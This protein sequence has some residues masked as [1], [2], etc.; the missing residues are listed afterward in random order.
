MARKR[1]IRGFYLSKKM[2]LQFR[3]R[4]SWE[5]AYFEYLDESN[6]VIGFHVEPMKIP[7]IYRKRK[8][9]YIPDI[10]IKYANRSILVEIKPKNFLL[11]KINLAKFQAARNVLQ[12][13]GID[14]F[15]VIT[16]DDLK[17][18]GL[19]PKKVKK[20]KVKHETRT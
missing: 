12:S 14:E 16:E 7:Y 6:D 4:S 13:M 9:N 17:K 11:R 1:R 18:L 3:F 19:F 8:R 2:N 5:K 20:T 10:L 15:I